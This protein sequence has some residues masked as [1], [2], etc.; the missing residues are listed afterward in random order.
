MAKKFIQRFI[1]NQ[2]KLSQ[3]KAL[4]W[5]GPALFHPNLW[6]INRESIARGMALGVFMGFLIP[7]GQIFVAA[8][9]AVF[10]RANL[11]TAA[12]ATLVTNPFTFAPIYFFAYQL[13]NFM[14]GAA[15]TPE[16]TAEMLNLDPEL[17]VLPPQELKSGISGWLVQLEGLG[18][19]LF[20]GLSTLAVSGAAISYFGVKALW[21]LQVIRRLEK[22]RRGSSRPST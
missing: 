4:R 11:P 7:I 22:K 6:H 12:V 19:P 18:A 20:L 9:F 16:V 15:P 17:L 10:L 14:L 8:V 13:G 1:P 21:R 2:E 5:L 3:H